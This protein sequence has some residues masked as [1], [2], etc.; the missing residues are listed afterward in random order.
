MILKIRSLIDI[1]NV[2]ITTNLWIHTHISNNI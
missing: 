1:S 2:D